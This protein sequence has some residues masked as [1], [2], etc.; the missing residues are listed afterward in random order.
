MLTDDS[1]DNSEDIYQEA[2]VGPQLY[3]YMDYKE[4]SQHALIRYFFI[5]D[6]GIDKD[7]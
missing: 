1:F 6:D 4:I 2:N 3:E 7:E 5:A